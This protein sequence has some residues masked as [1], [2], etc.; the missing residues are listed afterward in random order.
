[1]FAFAACSEKPTPDQDDQ[2]QTETPGEQP[3]EPGDEP[4]EPD[5]PETFEWPN[6]E[7]AFDYGLNKDESKT[8]EMMGFLDYFNSGENIPS[9]MNYQITLDKVTYCG[10][11]TKLYNNPRM[12]C[13][14]AKT[15]ENI[16]GISLPTATTQH[17]YFKI[18]RPGTLSFF[19]RYNN[20]LED[21]KIYVAIVTT[22]GDKVE[23]KFLFEGN[24]VVKSSNQ[25]DQNK[26]ECRISVAVT[27]ADMKGITEAATIYVFHKNGSAGEQM[28]YYPI[29]WTSEAVGQTT[30]RQAKF[31]LAG[32]SLVTEYKE[33]AA[34]QTGWGQCLA[35]ALGGNVSVVN[36]ARG[37]ESVVS[38]VENEKWDNLMSQT[39]RDDIVM[40]QFMHN[41][42][43]SVDIDTYKSYLK[44]FISDVR[45]KEA[46]PVLVTSVLRRQF[47][48]GLPTRNLGEFPIAMR[49]VADETDTPLI[50]CE[51]W[52][53]GWL[54]ELGADGA[55]DYY[56][57]N[58][59]DPEKN[60]ETHF[61]KEGAEFVAEFIADELV[62][63]GI[64][65]AAE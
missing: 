64:W 48:D 30:Q 3:E 41:D 13:N 21:T 26:P 9:T 53:Y 60:D 33:D 23:G 37:G 25:G 27:E 28:S 57:L 65:T 8:A 22:A 16:G 11:E 29:T 46:N 47:K 12:S 39:V 62:R 6:D 49:A 18:N 54:T 5:I 19:P 51:E 56:I 61:T 31:L 43:K 35:A 17:F 50:D 15:F 40:I 10:N 7:D 44:R 36:I 32:D 34:P 38:F 4:G 24:A 42:Q 63:L 58:K 55:A 1:M 52:S 20:F 2:Q 59:R 45:A 14:R